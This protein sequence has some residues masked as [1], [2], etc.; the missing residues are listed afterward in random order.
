MA[1][2]P[3]SGTSTPGSPATAATLT[4]IPPNQAP[5]GVAKET[6]MPLPANDGVTK[7]VREVTF[8]LFRASGDP[9]LEEVK[10]SPHLA[11]CPVAAILAAHAFTVD[12]RVVIKNIVSAPTFA[13][14]V[15]DV[16]A[17]PP[18]T[19]ENPPPGNKVTSSRYFKVTLPGGVR[20][21][22][23]VMYTDDAD[24]GFSL[25]YLH[26]PSDGSLWAGI[27][28]KALA[29]EIGSY[30]NFDALPL[31]A[32]DWWEKI[33]GVAPGGFAI[34]A[35]TPLSQITDAAQASITVPTI[36]ASKDDLP[37]G[38]NITAFHG[39]AMIGMLGT[40]VHLY[41]PAQA[42]KIHIPP[43]EFRQKFKAI[44]FTL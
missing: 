10:Q 30:E 37:I 6:T 34:T 28:E 9:G 13:N 5:S 11:N 18:D 25:I 16:S 3:T 40:E 33:T 19:L 21:P 27:I 26:D 35:T 17:L 4:E 29:E 23:D 41:D 31:S 38:G 24:A 20:E 42:I 22:S 43:S 44:L 39:F 8:P 1:L 32:N 2:P 36:G 14:V 12:G 15:T 7:D